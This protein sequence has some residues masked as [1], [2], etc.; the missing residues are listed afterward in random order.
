MVYCG[1]P[2]DACQPCR[3]KRRKC[4]RKRPCCTQCARANVPCPGYPDPVSSYFRNETALVSQRAQEKRAPR[5]KSTARSQGRE[6]RQPYITSL[7]TSPEDVALAYFML[8]FAP[9]SPF[10]YLP[11]LWSGVELDRDVNL[12]VN[13]YTLASL[14]IGSSQPELMVLA[15]S[16]YSK[17]L[18][19]THEALGSPQRALL[20]STLLTILLLTAFEAVVFNGR[21]SPKSWAVHVQGTTGLLTMRGKRQFQSD[22]GQRLFHQASMNV[23][24]ICALQRIP[25]PRQILNLQKDASTV[26]ETRSGSYRLEMLVERFVA[27][28]AN[29]KGMLA[30]EVVREASELDKES[31]TLLEGKKLIQPYKVMISEDTFAKARTYKGI[32]HEYVSQ[33]SARAYNIF[34]MLRLFFNEW[35]YCAYQQDLRGVILNRPS[36]ADPLHKE[37]DYLPTK[38]ALQGEEMIDEIL[39]SVPYTLELL[40]KSSSTSAR[41]LIWPLASVGTSELCPVSAK[42]F[43]IDR[44]K[45]LT[46]IHNVPQALEAATMLEEGVSI[47]DW[48]HIFHFS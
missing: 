33:N 38:A 12:A 40:E 18:A 46:E 10:H 30:T 7:S 21:A 41:L 13:G 5:L 35:I 26:L 47:E 31:K 19:R 24:A 3:T 43:V 32:L 39:A 17:A 4:D 11:G 16:Y 44:L 48:L 14:A 37:W 25:P 6:R 27:L 42:R 28:R 8:S 1:K 34:R 22:L 23:L 2:S 29:M 45:V 15:R 20:D 9:T 36:T